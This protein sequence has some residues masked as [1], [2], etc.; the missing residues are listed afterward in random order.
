MTVKFL[1]FVT[2]T[3][4]TLIELGMDKITNQ[5]AWLLDASDRKYISKVQFPKR[6][7]LFVALGGALE[8]PYYEIIEPIGARVWCKE[9]IKKFLNSVIEILQYES[10]YMTIFGKP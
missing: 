3:D 2:F 4:E 9:P 10:Y 1:I 5:G 7:M 8:K 6:A